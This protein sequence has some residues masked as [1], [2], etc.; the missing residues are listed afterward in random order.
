MTGRSP[1][2]LLG[3]R[4][5]GWAPRLRALTRSKQLR[6]LAVGAF[7]TLFGYV[8]F[9]ALHATLG[10]VVHYLLVLL[11]AHVVS[12]LVAFVGYRVIVFRVHGQVLKDLVRFW[13]V[14]V[15]VLAANLLA[16][17]LMI[18]VAGLPVLVAQGVFTVVTALA[19][20]VAHGRFSF[21][22]PPSEPER[23]AEEPCQP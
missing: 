3:A 5:A 14:Y 1:G 23:R 12:V 7:N 21:S 2:T 4:G 8:V 13:S 9:V 10:E 15:S 22:R 16:L 11:L 19:S 6:Y 20:Y 17:P 18:E